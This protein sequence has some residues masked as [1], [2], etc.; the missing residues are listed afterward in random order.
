MLQNTTR[1]NTLKSPV[2]LFFSR[3]T[4]IALHTS[5]HTLHP[6]L[7]FDTFQMH[8]SAS[9]S[10]SKNTMTRLPSPSLNFRQIKQC[11]YRLKKVIKNSISSKQQPKI[12]VLILWMLTEKTIDEIANIFYQLLRRPP[13]AFPPSNQHYRRPPLARQPTLTCWKRRLSIFINGVTG[14]NACNSSLHQFVSKLIF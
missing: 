14:R 7:I 4:N 9:A 13:P 1:D 11:A 3:K 12:P 6:C 10:F 2:K 5:D 8:F